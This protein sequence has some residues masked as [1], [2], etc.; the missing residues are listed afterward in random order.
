MLRDL[1]AFTTLETPSTEKKLLDAF[2]DYL[3]RYAGGLEATSVDIIPQTVAGNHVRM[4]WA[5]SAPATGR[6]ILVLAHFDT[7]WPAGTLK[8]IPFSVRDGVVRGPG[9]F[10]MK[11]GLVQGLWALRALL[12]G[13]RQYRSVTLV[14]NSDEEIGSE[15]SRALIEDEARKADAVFV[16][17][18]SLAGALK[19]SRKGQGTFSIDV[20][21]RAAHA[22]LDPDAGISAVHE[23]ARIVPELVELADPSQGTT[24][25][26][27]VI[28]GGTRSNVVAASAHA[29]VDIRIRTAAEADRVSAGIRALRPSR[30]G[31]RL[32]V[33]GGLTRPPLERTT[34]VAR[35][36]EQA[37]S[38]ASEI[39]LDLREA[40][41]GGASD[42]NFCAAV[43]I[44]VLDGLG[45]VGGG[46]HAPDE[47]VIVDEMPRRAALLA[48][49]LEHQ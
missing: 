47:H 44:P 2:A 42:G 29:E 24:V 28:A 41:A 16:L 48:A 36:Y 32:H 15:T 11:A 43:G 17:E 27:G 25:N 13:S 45:A 40:A 3:A 6:P 9:V 35:L 12:S 7:V 8:E 33:A 46:A 5:H 23:L 39:D 19:T 4:H 31:L 14:C 10:D 22:G 20:Q 1:E 34:G 38:L 37:R 18:P 30:A 21:G 49:L 26:V